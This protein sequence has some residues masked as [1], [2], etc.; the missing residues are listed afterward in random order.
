MNSDHR[1]SVE[2]TKKD[3]GSSRDQRS[4]DQE[5][6]I[7]P[8]CKTK[9]YGRKCGIC[10]TYRDAPI[11]CKC[12]QQNSGTCQFCSAC[13]ARLGQKKKTG[14]TA[15]FAAVIAV[16]VLLAVG[17]FTVHIWTEA[18][19]TEP[20]VCRICGKERTAAL[21]H[22]WRKATC[23]E[24]ET[25]ETCGAT[26]GTTLDHQWEPATCSVPETCE[27]CGATRGTTLD[28]QWMDATHQQA[29]TCAECGI[30]NGKSLP[31]PLNWCH[32]IETT[33]AN[34]SQGDDV[35][36]GSFWDCFDGYHSDSVQ[37]WVADFSRWA[38]A[39]SIVYQLGAG[40]ERLEFTIVASK[41]NDPIGETR[42]LIYADDELVYSSEWVGNNTKPIRESLDVTN[43]RRLK[44]E[45]TT[46][47]AAFCYCIFDAQL[48]VQG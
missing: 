25:C 5:L 45:C 9:N 30:T 28:H 11:I 14:K 35:A 22:K 29:R 19:C 2:Q 42:I 41:D 46:D 21:G 13:G 40:Y 26:R 23:F 36:R 1:Q 17:F 12:G 38:D 32:V 33:N 4:Q 10:G 43:V 15:I 16:V 27:T 3:P 18:S 7:C 24:P 44:I 39:E 37:F 34:D 47:S 20:S 31:C 8:N 48:Y 6:W